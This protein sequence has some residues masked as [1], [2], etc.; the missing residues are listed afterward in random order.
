MINRIDRSRDWAVLV[1]RLALGVTFIMHGIPKLVSDGPGGFAGFLRGLGFPLPH[2]LAWIV[3]V[4]EVGG[5]AA[6]VLGVLV[7]YVG[8]L[9][10][11]E[12]L[13]TTLRVKVAGGVGF[14]AQRGAGWELD[15]VLAAAALAV[16]LLG[17]GAFALAPGS[18]AKRRRFPR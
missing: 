17:P 15:M 13:V 1:L 4:L 12:M 2:L 10:I 7:R 16:V 14:I 3:A 5:G 6:M 8:G 9:L 18:R 11:V